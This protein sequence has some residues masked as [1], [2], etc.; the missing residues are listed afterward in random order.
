MIGGG[1]VV[2]AGMI[3]ALS[4]NNGSTTTVHDDKVS[5]RTKSVTGDGQEIQQPSVGDS[6]SGDSNQTANVAASPDQVNDDRSPEALNVSP[7]VQVRA[8]DEIIRTKN[9]NDPRL[10]TTLKNLAP[11]T[12]AQLRTRYE[13]FPRERR[14]ARGLTVFLIGR[15]MATNDDVAFISAVLDEAPCLSLGDCSKPPQESG[16][17]H[18]G[19]HAGE[20]DQGG[21]VSL[22]YPQLV[23]VRMLVPWLK[24]NPEHPSR[25][26]II[27]DLERAAKSENSALSSAAAAALSQLRR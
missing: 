11:E 16:E 18:E 25:A 7:S 9:D 22:A 1:V 14:N 23:A 20:G 12:K 6:I 26:S 24:K 8:F 2:L 21:E 27:A 10:D 17:A 3:W 5:S 13:S 19:I 15:E 4:A